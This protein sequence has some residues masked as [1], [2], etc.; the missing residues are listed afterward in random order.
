MLSLSC[1]INLLRC[2]SRDRRDD[3]RKPTNGYGPARDNGFTPTMRESGDDYRSRDKD[4]YRTGKSY[5]PC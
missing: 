3:S 5:P 4:R 1:K 2:S